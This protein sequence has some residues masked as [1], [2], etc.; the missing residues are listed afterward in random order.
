M[1]RREHVVK[2]WPSL[3]EGHGGRAAEVASRLAFKLDAQPAATASPKSPASASGPTTWSPNPTRSAA[4][5]PY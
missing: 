1:A 4:A 3:A 5:S 2:S